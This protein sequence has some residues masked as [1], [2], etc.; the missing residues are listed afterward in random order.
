MSCPTN[1]EL[2]EYYKKEDEKKEKKYFSF[3]EENDEFWMFRK[4]RDDINI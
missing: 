2:K 4:C 3:K 1:E